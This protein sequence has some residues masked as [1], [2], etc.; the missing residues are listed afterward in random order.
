[1]KSNLF[2]ES[3]VIPADEHR[4]DYWCFYP[5]YFL[6][7]IE[8]ENC[9]TASWTDSFCRPEQ[10][11]EWLLEAVCARCGKTEACNC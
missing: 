6:F 4:D 7:A 2:V 1:M 10:K 5:G 9:R 3:N 11:Q 8:P